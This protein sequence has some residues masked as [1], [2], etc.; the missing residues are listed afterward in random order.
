M[1]HRAMVP[2][3][4]LALGLSA[5]SEPTPPAAPP[6][7]LAPD[8]AGMWSDPPSTALDMFCFF[9]CTD[10]GLRRL[11][12]LLDDP[13]ND[14]R[15]YPDLSADAAQHQL[16]EY[17]R[18]HLTDAALAAPMPDPMQDPGYLR[19]EPWGF[20]R[21][22]FAPHQLEIKQYADRV[23]LHY[24]EWD[25]HRIVHLRER[26]A[27]ADHVPMG[28]SV[29]HYE[30][31]TLVVETTLITP[32]FGPT[33]IWEGLHSDQLTAVERY[34]RPSPERLELTAVLTDPSTFREPVELKKIWRFAPEQEIA[35]YDCVPAAAT[36]AEGKTP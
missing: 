30:G 23:E 3:A 33:R 17:L 36:V 12:A 29:G 22:T 15:P 13:A 26:A 28:Y 20:A 5:C 1:V 25:A 27:A 16:D 21:Q 9:A 4:I 35:P 8:L 10:V 32:N 19:C 14:A 31:D 6:Q 2:I 24:G 11:A 18:P 7:P 34:R